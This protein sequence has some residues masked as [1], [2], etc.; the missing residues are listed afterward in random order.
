MPHALEIVKGFLLQLQERLAVV[1]V[2]AEP[3]VVGLRCLRLRCAPPRAMLNVPEYAWRKSL[4]PFTF[5]PGVVLLS[6]RRGIHN[7]WPAGNGLPQPVIVQVP[8]P[9]SSSLETL[10]LALLAQHLALDLFGDVEMQYPVPALEVEEVTNLRNL[11]R[12]SRDHWG[13]VRGQ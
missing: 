10:S 6:F 2:L 11:L 7:G 12:E 8:L 13:R 1:R 4:L 3:S 9:E 5:R